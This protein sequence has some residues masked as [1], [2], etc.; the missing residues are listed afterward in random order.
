MSFDFSSDLL[1]EKDAFFKK[2]QPTA[3][4]PGG[5]A[6]LEFTL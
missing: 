2:P 5:A 6:W 1:T 3:A 4:S